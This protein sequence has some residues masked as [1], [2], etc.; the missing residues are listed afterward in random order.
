MNLR[1]FRLLFIAVLML[2]SS[3]ILSQF[4]FQH[5]QGMR[6]ADA[7]QQ[8]AV[9]ADEVLVPI[10]MQGPGLINV[11]RFFFF[12][13]YEPNKLSFQGIE[14]AAI[15]SL[16]ANAGGNTLYLNWNNPTNPINCTSE[17]IL[18]YLKFNRIGSGDAELIFKPGSYVGTQSNFLAVVYENGIV[19]QEYDLDLEAVPLSGGTLS[20]AGTYLPGQQITV[21]ANHASGYSFVNWT[22]NGNPLSDSPSFVYTMPESSVLL[23]ANFQ[24]NDYLLSLHA[25]PSEGGSL[26]GG[27][28]YHY[29]QHV[30]AEAVAAIGYSFL[31]WKKDGEIVS[32]DPNYSFQMSA[33]NLDLWAEFH[34]ELYELTI[35]IEPEDA[36]TTTGAAAY[37][38][39]NQVTVRAF[40][41]EGY[42]FK[43]WSLNGNTVSTNKS[44]S[45]SMPPESIELDAIFELNVYQI[46][47]S[48]NDSQ[49]GEVSGGGAYEHNSPVTV[50]AQANESYRFI[51]WVSESEIVSFDATYSFLAVSDLQLM[52]VF[53][54][55]EYCPEPTA[56]SVNELGE[57]KAT[58]HWVSPENITTWDVLW[59]KL[60]ADTLETS[61]LIEGLQENRLTIDTLSAQTYYG[62][63][64]RAYCEDNS[65]SDWSDLGQFMT[66]YVGNNE[67]ED[68]F[69]KLYPQPASDFVYVEVPEAQLPVKLQIKSLNAEL[70]YETTLI[71]QYRHLISVAAFR[72]GVYVLQLSSDKKI[73]SKP[74]LIV[75]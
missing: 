62:F 31:H 12:V 71:D 20:G 4:S 11:S 56:L 63:Y 65:L 52:A 59:G 32:V 54:F 21:S 22:H 36:G 38:Y 58:L 72:S 75:R 68:S 53:Q 37:H 49:A 55:E 73:H 48:A 19:Y 13:Q 70:L 23:Q 69:I 42:H 45:F 61:Y 66:Y 26:S 34:H 16:A 67:K 14:A 50:S 15:S 18:F 27:G 2:K 30:T 33:S 3:I 8:L 10:K 17:T 7:V 47:V 51:A 74:L 44:Y 25:N 41:E 46:D 60:L 28:V 1:M 64:V 40:P 35:N 5:P 39:N 9:S 57:N 6:T 29:G 43:E 24:L